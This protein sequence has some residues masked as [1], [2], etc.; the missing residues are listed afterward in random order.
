MANRQKS[1]L[2]KKEQRR[3]TN[4]FTSFFLFFSYNLLVINMNEID[5]SK[6]VNIINKKKKNNN[7]NSDTLKK[8]LINLSIK[9]MVVIVVL[10]S[11]AILYKGSS[12][13]KADI[14]N[15]FFSENVSFTKIKKIYNKYLGGLLPLKKDDDITAVFDEKLQFSDSSIYYD[16]VK[17]L[18]SDNYLVPTLDEGMVVFVGDKENYG[19]TIII[20]N[21][22]GI[23]FWYGNITSTSLKLYDYV[24]KGSLIGEVNNDLY[25]VFSKDGK[26]LNYEEYIY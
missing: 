22:D 12:S 5:P 18:V 17:L 16:G 4:S 26:Y 25:M 15:Y 14:S 7:S 23:Y 13:L 21:L 24:E 3:K 19:K 6:Y 10:V 2:E 20:E 11:L 1:F 8:I 9:S